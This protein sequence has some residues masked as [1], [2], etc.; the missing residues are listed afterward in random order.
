[1][2]DDDDPVSVYLLPNSGS[3]IRDLVEQVN[4]NHEMKGKIKSM[5]VI[6]DEGTRF[7]AR[8]D[9]EISYAEIPY[10]GEDEYSNFEQDME[11]ILQQNMGTLI[12]VPVDISFDRKEGGE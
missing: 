11:T 7:P 3:L 6:H 1:M 5:H 12:A 4:F 2:S 9:I 8:L 10:A